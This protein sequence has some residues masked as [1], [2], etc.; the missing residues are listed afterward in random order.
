[1]STSEKIRRVIA[2][3]LVI[4]MI[5]SIVMTPVPVTAFVIFAVLGIAIAGLF[6]VP[7]SIWDWVGAA[8]LVFGPDWIQSML[9][10]HGLEIPY[11]APRL[12]A[13]GFLVIAFYAGEALLGRRAPVTAPQ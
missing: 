5:V 1:M 6:L 11:I 3:A 7:G 2:V 9:H 8:I 13:V 4:A 10:K 12:V